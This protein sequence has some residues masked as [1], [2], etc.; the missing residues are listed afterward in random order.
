MHR[1]DFVPAVGVGWETNTV[2]PFPQ[3]QPRKSPPFDWGVLVPFLIHPLRVA[4]IEAL[5]W[6]D[7]PLSASELKRLFGED[8]RTVGLISYHVNELAKTGVIRK[9]GYRQRRGA[10]ETFYQITPQD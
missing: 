4:I 6:I 8:G 1:Q 5:L 2:M 7:R 9:Q 3:H 10:R